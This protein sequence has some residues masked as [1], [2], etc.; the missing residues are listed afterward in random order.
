[1]R[2]WCRLFGWSRFGRRVIDV[3][4]GYLKALGDPQEV[5]E[6]VLG[7]TYPAPV[8]ELEDLAEVPVRKS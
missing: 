5:I 3:L 1:M 2:L 8:D 4:E 7:Q 6:L